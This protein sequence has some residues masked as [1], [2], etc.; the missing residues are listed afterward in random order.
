M[1]NGSSGRGGTGKPRGDLGVRTG[2]WRGKSRIPKKNGGQTLER[3][4]EG[5]LRRTRNGRSDPKTTN[6]G[7]LRP[8]R[9]WS[10]STLPL[11]SENPYSPS[12]H[13]RGRQLLFLFK[14]SDA[15]VCLFV[16]VLVL[17]GSCHSTDLR[18]GGS[19]T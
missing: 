8:T 11:V 10:E 5:Y 16:Q 4:Q 9:T 1:L 17:F 13:Q 7:H 18:K 14:R 12:E 6:T 19:H 3:A 15:V 2:L